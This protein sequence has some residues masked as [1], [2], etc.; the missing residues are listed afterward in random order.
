MLEILERITGGEGKEGD[1]ELL[2]RLAENT[3][4]TSLCALGGSAPNPV[5]S[6]LEHFR[7]EYEA[8]IYDDECPAG[9]CQEL[10]SAYVIE[11]DT[12]I[13]CTNCV[14]TCPV[15]AISGEPKEVHE[16]DADLCISCGACVETCPVDAIYE[17]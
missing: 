9:V 3:K 13:G 16:I 4:E 15:D 2:E 12:C 10:S 5:L 17:G 14:D 8:H 11:A 7:D 6:T 1:I